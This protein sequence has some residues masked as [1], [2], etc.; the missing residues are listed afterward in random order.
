MPGMDRLKQPATSI[1]TV[2]H[3][4]KHP[5]QLIPRFANTVTIVTVN[6]EDQALCVLE[7]VSP[8]WSN[9][10]TTSAAVGLGS[11]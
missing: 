10:N 7:V 1:P 11:Q 9:L 2:K 3:L 8:Q 5:V 4:V 6:H